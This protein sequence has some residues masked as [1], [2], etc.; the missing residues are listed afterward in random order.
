MK[1]IILFINI[2]NYVLCDFFENLYVLLRYIYPLYWMHIIAKHKNWR[3]AEWFLHWFTWDFEIKGSQR[4]AVRFISMNSINNTIAFYFLCLMTTP[5]NLFL[6]LITESI[7]NIQGYRLLLFFI[8]QIPFIILLIICLTCKNRDE[9]YIRVFEKRYKRCLTKWRIYTL[10]FIITEF[11]GV[12][13]ILR[14]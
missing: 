7:F 3:K 5:I 2:L 6:V 4:K 8:W 11:T 13:L 1:R 12:I 9:R 14:K 10:V